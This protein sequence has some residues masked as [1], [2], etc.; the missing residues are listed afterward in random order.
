MEEFEK[1][2]GIRVKKALRFAGALV[3]AL[4]VA[5]FVSVELPR[6]GFIIGAAIILACIAAFL[7][8]K[9]VSLLG[10]NR[11]KGLEKELLRLSGYDRDRADRLFIHEMSRKPGAAR[12]EL[13]QN[14]ID[15]L[16]DDRRR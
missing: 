2:R 15:R 3:A 7:L 12:A 16:L 1:P 13:L 6:Y 4:V 14:A 8:P 5:G 11:E 9:A 10:K